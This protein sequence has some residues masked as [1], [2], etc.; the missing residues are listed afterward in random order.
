MPVNISAIRSQNSKHFKPL[1]LPF[2][3]YQHNKL[4]SQRSSTHSKI[5]SKSLA[6]EGS[7][8]LPSILKHSQSYAGSNGEQSFLFGV[9]ENED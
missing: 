1:P 6:D 5:I 3:V 8:Q 4:L 7:T 9:E 2:Q